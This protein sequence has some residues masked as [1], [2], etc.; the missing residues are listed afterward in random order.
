MLVHVR[1]GPQFACGLGEMQEGMGEMAILINFRLISDAGDVLKYRCDDSSGD[2][3]IDF[4]VHKQGGGFE[5]PQGDVP[6][7]SRAARAVWKKFLSDGTWPSS[8]VY[9]A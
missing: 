7:A 3:S 1:V 6:R 2:M 9:A 8:G 5:S 4:I